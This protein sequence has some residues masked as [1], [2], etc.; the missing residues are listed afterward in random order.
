MASISTAERGIKKRM[1]F[2]R[3]KAGKKSAGQRRNEA[4]SAEVSK[5]AESKAARIATN[6]GFALPRLEFE[7]A[8]EIVT[9]NEENWTAIVRDAAEA[10]GG[11]LLFVL[12]YAEAADVDAPD[13]DDG[14]SPADA[15]PI[16][17][18]IMRYAL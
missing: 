5:T 2:R 6:D 12:P 3:K 10:A 16:D 4:I 13:T 18:A 15:A 1:S 9:P 14:G 8:L 17:H 7:M 11:D